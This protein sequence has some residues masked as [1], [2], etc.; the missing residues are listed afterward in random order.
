VAS[1]MADAGEGDGLDGA[2][3][4]N[5]WLMALWSSLVIPDE[6]FLNSLIPWPRPLANSGI[7]LAPN[8]TKAAT[9][10]ITSS[11]PPRPMIAK[12]V[13]ISIVNFIYLRVFL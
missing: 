3:G 8:K 2:D 9:R 12:H 11:P 1:G 4:D 10:T 6:A 13:F 5:S 7:L